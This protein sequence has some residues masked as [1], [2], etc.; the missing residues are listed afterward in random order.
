[1]ELEFNFKLNRSERLTL[2]K[3]LWDQQYKINSDIAELRGIGSDWTQ[4]ELIKL[5]GKKAE[6]YKLQIKLEG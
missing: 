1:M 4:D 2:L 6:L 3:G 5:E